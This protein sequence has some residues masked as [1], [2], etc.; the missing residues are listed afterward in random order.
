MTSIDAAA[1]QPAAFA[2]IAG[3]F[4]FLDEWDDR[5][6]YIIEL[7]RELP[8]LDETLRTDQ[9]KV[10]G[11]VSQVWLSAS[12]NSDNDADP[13][14]TFH[15]DSDAQ[16]VK[17]LVYIALTLFN[18]R[19]ASEILTTDAMAQL[20]SIGLDKQITPQRNNGLR[21]MVERAQELARQ[22]QLSN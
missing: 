15:A 17:G 19:R 1:D 12:A 9:N 2:H 4:A 11:C 20:A 3:E 14:L 13:T 22:S 7:G 6:R 8:P 5:Y 10:K 21:S 18:G 16:I